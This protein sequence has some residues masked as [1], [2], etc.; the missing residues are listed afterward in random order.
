[1]LVG[2][3]FAGTSSMRLPPIRMAPS[4]M[5]SKPAMVRRSVVLP[6]PDGPSREKNSPARMVR[7]IPRSA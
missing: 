5:S 1:M 2:R 4:L 6:Q 3:L 7:S